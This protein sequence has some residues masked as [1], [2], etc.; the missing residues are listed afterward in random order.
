MNYKTITGGKNHLL[1][2]LCILWLICWFCACSFSEHSAEEANTKYS[3]GYRTP[4]ITQKNIY[5]IEATKTAGTSTGDRRAPKGFDYRGKMMHDS[6]PYLLI[7]LGTLAVSFVALCLLLIKNT[8]LGKDLEGLVKTRTHELEVQTATLTTVFSSIPDLIFCKDL[9]GKYTQCNQSFQRYINREKQNII[10]RND[11]DLF[12][13]RMDLVDSCL[14][15]DQ[16]LIRSGMSKTIEEYIYSP[17]L[18][19]AKLF[20]IIKTPLIQNGTVV[21]LMGIARDITER[22]AIEAAAQAASKAKSEFLARISHEIRTPLNA[23]IGMT[24]IARNSISDTQSDTQK[25]RNSLDEITTASSHL[26]NILNDVLDMAKIESGKFEII[27]EPF[28]LG[29]ALLEVSSIIFQRCKDKYIVFEN[30]I[31]ELPDAYLMGD[32]LRLNQVLI[33]LLGNAVKFTPMEGRIT[34]HI[35]VMADTPE[36]IKLKFILSDTGIGMSEDQL[37]RLFVAFEQADNTIAPRFGGTGLGLAISQNLVNLMGGNISV[38]SELHVGSTFS[39]ELDFPKA[40]TLPEVQQKSDVS[41]LDLSARR[42]LLVEDVEINRIILRELLAYTGIIIEEA[43][44]GQYALDMFKFSPV[45][46]YD[47]IFMDIQMPV[48]DGYEATRKIRSLDRPDAKTVSI[49]AMTANA[50]QEDINKA[51]GIGMN[52]HIAKPIDLPIVLRTLADVFKQ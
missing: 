9:Q 5:N 37:E 34:F 31:K 13:A 10:G 6:M 41:T 15:V 48:M 8:R 39:F 17:Y 30:N 49:I 23:I 11:V 22:K 26:L 24:H 42:I 18:E 35:E 28:Y 1:K 29:S 47:L 52:G 44:D 51:L 25:V 33:N 40:E 43:A 16:E 4:G 12:G 46:Y 27:Q 2:K 21:G 45:G 36:K 3:T 32:K 7:G 20:E 14:K 19:D 50:Y 38:Q